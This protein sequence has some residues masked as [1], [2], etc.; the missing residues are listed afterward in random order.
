MVYMAADN[1]LSNY[2]KVD[3]Q[4]LEIGCNDN[5]TLKYLFLLI[6]IQM[7]IQG[8]IK[9]NTIYIHGQLYQSA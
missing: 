3:L 6:R 7:V 9:L 4:E 5:D 2:A 1:D 8:Y